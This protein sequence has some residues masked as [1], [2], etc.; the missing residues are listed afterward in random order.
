M[1]DPRKPSDNLYKTHDMSTTN[2][3]FMMHPGQFLLAESVEW[4][5]LPADI[6]GHLDGKSSL[7]RFGLAVH[8]TAPRFDPGWKG[9]I[10]FEL[11]NNLPDAGQPLYTGMRIA[12]MEFIELAAPVDIPYHK[13]ESAKYKNQGSVDVSRSHLEFPSGHPN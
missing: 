8:S 2:N 1:V 6:V 5:E 12:A 11:K 4:L 3:E 7:G 10:R 13:R 9:K